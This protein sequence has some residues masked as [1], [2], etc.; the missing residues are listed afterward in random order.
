[1][2]GWTL[3]FVFQFN[4]NRVILSGYSRISFLLAQGMRGNFCAGR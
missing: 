4:F 1:M 2:L 3:T